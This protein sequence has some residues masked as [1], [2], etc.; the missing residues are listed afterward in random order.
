MK[1][2]KHGRVIIFDC[3]LCGCRYAAGAN[4]TTDC[5]FF[6]KAICPECGSVNEYKTP[7]NPTKEERSEQ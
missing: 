3:K 4:E 1:V 5:G 2:I 7:P 6:L